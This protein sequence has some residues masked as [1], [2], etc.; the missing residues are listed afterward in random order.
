M[1]D[2]T[3]ESTRDRC[4]QSFF[5]PFSHSNSTQPSERVHSAMMRTALINTQ[6]GKS[7]QQSRF[8]T[9][10]NKRNTAPKCTA[11]HR[12]PSVL[13]HSGSAL[14]RADTCTQINC[15]NKWQTNNRTQIFAIEKC[16]TKC[17]IFLQ[18]SDFVLRI[19]VGRL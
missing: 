19:F 10:N 2:R 18:V 8:R 12:K 6:H 11:P 14:H 9:V 4:P 3:Q 13:Q 5:L 17:E 16:S 1:R 15:R 7:T